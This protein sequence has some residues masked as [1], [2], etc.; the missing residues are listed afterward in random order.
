MESSGQVR[1]VLLFL[2]CHLRHTLLTF[3][4]FNAN[5]TSRSNLI[6]TMDS[7]SEMYD[8]LLDELE[9]NSTRVKKGDKASNGYRLKD[10]LRLPRATTY[11]T[12]ALYG[13]PIIA[14]CVKYFVDSLYC[15]E[16]IIGGDINLEPEYQRGL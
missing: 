10:V 2:H 5:D 3:N 1:L 6:L 16:Q 4:V 11:T 14:I 8:E 7:D 15:T 13:T 12:Q 9:S